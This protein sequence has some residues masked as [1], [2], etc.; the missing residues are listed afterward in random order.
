M[1]KRPNLADDFGI[2]HEGEGTGMGGSGSGRHS[3]R[4]VLD[5]TRRLDVNRWNREGMFAGRES[6]SWVWMDEERNVVASIGYSASRGE[7][8]LTYTEEPRTEDA[9][10]LSYRVPVVWTP[11]TFG[12]ERPW[13]VCPNRYCGRRAAK[14]YLCGGYFVCRTCTGM[15]YQSQREDQSGRLMLKAQRIRRRLGAG[16]NLSE[17][18]PPKPKGM[19]WRTYERLRRE[20]EWANYNSLVLALRAWG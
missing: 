11:C 13:F 8:T 19:H 1:P 15:G 18:F 6:G 5:G 2:T 14:L 3:Y 12:G 20:E 10:T 16:P 7:V 9:R 17:P 4:G